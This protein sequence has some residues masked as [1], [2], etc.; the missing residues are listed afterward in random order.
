M[1]KRGMALTSTQLQAVGHSI[2]AAALSARKYRFAPSA[3]AMASVLR[4]EDGQGHTT[5]KTL[6]REP[7]IFEFG[8]MIHLSSRVDPINGLAFMAP[9]RCTSSG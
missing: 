3:L 8:E 9:F 5:I 6:P 2:F 4:G 7:L 1:R